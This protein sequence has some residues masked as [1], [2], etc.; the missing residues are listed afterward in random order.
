MKTKVK[1][2]TTNEF[3][4]DFKE[5]LIRDFDLTLRDYFL[6]DL[7]LTVI[8]ESV[9]KQVPVQIGTYERWYQ[10]K[11]ENNKEQINR[12][13]D[14]PRLFIKQSDI[15]VIEDKYI[16]KIVHTDK[17]I[18]TNYIG[19]DRY[20]KPIWEIA[21]IT[22]PT[23]IEISYD[24]SFYC[25]KTNQVNEIVQQII[26][27]DNK[28]SITTSKGF[29][30]KMV[31]SGFSDNSNIDD[32]S[33][34]QRLLGKTFTIN[35]GGNFFIAKDLNTANITKHYTSPKISYTERIIRGDQ[36]TINRDNEINTY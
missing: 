9:R 34:E 1:N 2:I 10:N 26:S 11:V 14:Y 18:R 6:K 27:K 25:W 20:G 28:I 36:T 31:R 23:Y 35:M 22:L 33:D 8:D 30:V 13:T 17:V 5:N 29:Y 3:L 7:K 4:E 21:N 24:I 12:Q 15:D 16:P 32:F 19:K